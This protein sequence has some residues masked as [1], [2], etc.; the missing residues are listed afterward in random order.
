LDIDNAVKVITE[1]AQSRQVTLLV[2]AGLSM[3]PPTNLPSW[4][5]LIRDMAAI[6]KPYSSGYAQVMIEEADRNELILAGDF[7]DRGD[8]VPRSVRAGF[9]ATT[10]NKESKAVPD[11]YELAAKFPAHV[12]ATTNFDPNLAMPSMN[13]CS[14]TTMHPLGPS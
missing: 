12:F 11:S 1:I 7:F 2:G 8:V 6:V 9:F 4:Q 5:K 13:R 10:F 3:D 14:T